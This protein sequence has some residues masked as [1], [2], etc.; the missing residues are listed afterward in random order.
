MRYQR[1]LATATVDTDIMRVMAAYDAILVR[2]IY[3]GW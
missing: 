3:F 2:L 1:Q